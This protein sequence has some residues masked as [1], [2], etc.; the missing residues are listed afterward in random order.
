MPYRV[1]LTVKESRGNCPYYRV[2]D[3]IVFEDAEI[4]KEESGR[5]CIYALTALAPYLTA[6]CRDTPRE[7][8]INRKEVIQCPDVNRPVIFKVER[9]PLK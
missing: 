5:L 1:T 2:G 8:W 6:L 3:K 4:I 7:D 9:E